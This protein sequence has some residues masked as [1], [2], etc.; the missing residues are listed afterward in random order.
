MVK[1]AG[2]IATE[3]ILMLVVLLMLSGILY[4]TYWNQS[5]PNSGENLRVNAVD[6]IANDK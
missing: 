3:F 1:N 4:Q 5:D 6:K 2:Q